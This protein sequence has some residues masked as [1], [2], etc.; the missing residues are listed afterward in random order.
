MASKYG[1]QEGLRSAVAGLFIA[2]LVI[3]ALASEPGWA[4]GF[5]WILDNGILINVLAGA[6]MMVFLSMAF[7]HFAGRL[8]LVKGWNHLSTGVLT[9]VVVLISS[10]FLSGWLGFFNNGFK[11]A[12]DLSESF[13]DFIIKPFFWICLF[14]MAPATVIGIWFGRRVK[15]KKLKH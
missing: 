7:G 8:I 11:N 2:F 15:N 10:A 13:V 6:A 4:A 12:S 3:T 1:R 14:G 5:L 9:G